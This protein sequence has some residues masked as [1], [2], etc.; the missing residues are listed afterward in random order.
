[1][2]YDSFALN[3]PFLTFAVA[4]LQ[5]SAGAQR[6]FLVLSTTTTSAERCRHSK[7]TWRIAFA[8]DEGVMV[9]RVWRQLNPRNLF[10]QANFVSNLHFG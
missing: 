9:A 4:L 7:L 8:F 2:G 5:S 10:Q 3:L 1:M 6:V